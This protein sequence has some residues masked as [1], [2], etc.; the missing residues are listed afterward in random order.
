MQS[1]R[2]RADGVEDGRARREIL[3]STQVLASGALAPVHKFSTLHGC[4]VLLLD[5]V[6]AMP[7]WVDD[8]APRALDPRHGRPPASLLRRPSSPR[9]RAA[10]PSSAWATA[11]GGRP[12]GRA[13]AA[14]GP[15]SR[16]GRVAPPRALADCCPAATAT[17]A[18]CSRS[19]SRARRSNRS[20]TS[21]TSARSCTGATRPPLRRPLA[22]A[23]ARAIDGSGRATAYA[24]PRR[25]CRARAWWRARRRT[26]GR[27]RASPRARPPSG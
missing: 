19:R 23:P 25:R 15:T 1:S 18:A 26:A 11:P 10:R 20:C 13:P 22:R 9:P 16:L 21:S 12:R 3:I 5:E 7:Y 6:Q 4:A 2:R 17:S 8:P 24:W 27:A 14:A